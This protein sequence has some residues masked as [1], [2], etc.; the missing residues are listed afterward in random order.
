MN[1]FE[2]DTEL[3]INSNREGNMAGGWDGGRVNSNVLQA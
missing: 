1:L 2:G 3:K